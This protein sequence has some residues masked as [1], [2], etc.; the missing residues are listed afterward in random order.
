MTSSPGPAAVPQSRRVALITGGGGAIG[1]AIAAAM[2]A[3]G[4]R[5]VLA[6]LD[7]EAAQATAERIGAQS[8]V[9]TARLNVRDADEIKKLVSHVVE[10]FGAIDGLVTAAGGGNAGGPRKPFWETEL[11]DWKLSTEIYLM[12][13]LQTCHAALPFMLAQ[14]K[15]VICNVASGAGLRGGPP[16]TRQKFAAVYSASKGALIGFTQ[17]IA[18]EVAPLGIRVNCIAPGRTESRSKSLAEL[19]LRAQAEEVASPGS[20]RMSPL[21]RFGRAE[22]MGNAATFLMSDRASFITGS[23]LDLTGGI[24]LH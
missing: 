12:S 8:V 14:G 18:Q 11:A 16:S 15:G 22:D 21:G 5:L 7:L 10:R 3:D 1:S 2:A 24:R 4:W 19:E 23:C 6:D 17:S 20:S 9:E 13:V